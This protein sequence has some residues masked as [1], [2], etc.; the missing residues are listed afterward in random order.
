MF[1]NQQLLS[2]WLLPYDLFQYPTLAPYTVQTINEMEMG[3]RVVFRTT[4]PHQ[5]SHI[6]GVAMEV[7]LPRKHEG[8][9]TRRSYWVDAY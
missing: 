8:L 7:L 4:A 6:T 3:P 9:A 2:S 1:T 5:T